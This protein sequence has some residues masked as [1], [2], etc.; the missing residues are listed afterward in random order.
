MKTYKELQDKLNKY[1]EQHREEVTEINDYLANHPEPSGYEKNS[2]AKIV[3]FLR[4]KGFTVEYP[5]CG[6]DYAF[7]A[8]YG[9]QKHTRKAGIFCEYD[10]LPEIGHACGHCLSGS[11]SLLAALALIELQDDLDCD[12]H[13]FGSP[14]EEVSGCKM[15]FAEEGYLDGFGLAT[16]VHMY[17]KNIIAP[18]LIALDSYLYTFHGKV[19]HAAVNPWDGINALNAVKLMF[20][21]MDMLRQHVHPEVRMHAVIKEGGLA[22]NIV[23]DKATAE[24]YVR[25]PKWADVVDVVKK[26]DGCAEGGCN[27]TGATWEK[28][29]T[30]EPYYEVKPNATGHKV[31][32]DIYEELGLTA[33][34]DK[35]EIFGST[36]A[37]NVSY[38][39]PTFHPCLQVVDE[40]VL[41]HTKAFA[42]AMTTDRA[43]KVLVTGAK[44][45]GYQIA[46]TF[47]DEKILEATLKDNQ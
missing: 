6:F 12:I 42:D 15:N 32:E 23:P 36:D 2:S 16:M 30:A 24:V 13:I 29:R 4:G 27:A 31:L 14:L 5:F 43:H 28:A 33:V 40:D 37:G 46:K 35:S 19:A 41:I 8:V 47:S 39:C 34:P 1:I 21:G 38:V 22:A 44:I 20:H 45:I 18:Q 7:H 10:A 11:I 9:D 3:E 26:V 17:N 25:A